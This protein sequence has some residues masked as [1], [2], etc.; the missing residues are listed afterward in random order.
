MNAFT[1]RMRFFWE[2]G[3]FANED[4]WRTF[5]GVDEE[6]KPSFNTGDDVRQCPA[7]FLPETTLVK[8]SSWLNGGK[9]AYP[10]PIQILDYKLRF[11]E[12][13][14]WR[15]CLDLLTEGIQTKLDSQTN[16][17]PEEEALWAITSGGGRGLVDVVERIMEEHRLIHIPQRRSLITPIDNTLLGELFD[18]DSE[19]EECAECGEKFTP[20]SAAQAKPWKQVLDKDSRNRHL[21]D[22]L[23]TRD[24]GRKQRRSGNF[25]WCK[26]FGSERIVAQVACGGTQELVLDQKVGEW[27]DDESKR[28]YLWLLPWKAEIPI[29]GGACHLQTLRLKAAARSLSIKP[30]TTLINDDLEVVV[31]EGVVGPVFCM[32]RAQLTEELNRR[33]DEIE[34]QKEVRSVKKRLGSSDPFASEGLQI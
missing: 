33:K 3:L 8:I 10:S 4:A 5:Y 20:L 26:P 31:N 18:Y 23:I 15:V 24:K 17:R 16:L 9:F 29:I 1:A 13:F 2:L 27:L 22:L 25:V 12:G 11:E 21:R 19:D 32:D 7:F 34:Q 30:F 6:G 14:D 28:P